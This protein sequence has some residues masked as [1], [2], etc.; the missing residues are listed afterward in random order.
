MSGLRPQ[1]KE[2][3]GEEKRDYLLETGAGAARA[4]ACG[5]PTHVGE[6]VCHLAITGSTKLETQH[7]AQVRSNLSKHRVRG[8]SHQPLLSK[9]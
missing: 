8:S 2:H 5:V 7:T 3:H 1:Q 6:G 4:S 9:P